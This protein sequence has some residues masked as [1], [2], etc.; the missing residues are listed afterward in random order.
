MTDFS[1]F[2]AGRGLRPQPLDILVIN[3]K[4]SAIL[5]GDN[6]QLDQFGTV[7]TSQLFGKETSA[8]A[9]AVQ[10]H[11][12]STAGVVLPPYI[13]ARFTGIALAA[14]AT[15]QEGLVR[16]VGHVNKATVVNTS[17]STALAGTGCIAQI[18]GDNLQVA[19]TVPRANVTGVILA[20]IAASTT[21]VV[22]VLFKGDCGWTIQ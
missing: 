18:A 19:P 21:A 8:L 12:Q 11:N 14:I 22:P 5:E 20:S 4:G 17:A 13:G 2:Q 10:P 7:A 1:A 3:G 9:I 6:V 16:M 15:G